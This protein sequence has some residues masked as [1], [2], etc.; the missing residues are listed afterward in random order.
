MCQTCF[1]GNLKKKGHTTPHKR[2]LWQSIAC[3]KPG[4]PHLREEVWRQATIEVKSGWISEPNRHGKFGWDSEK[5][6]RRFPLHQQGKIRCADDFRK[7][8]TNVMT[9]PDSKITLP[10]VSTLSEIAYRFMQAGRYHFGRV[11]IRMFTGNYLSR[12]STAYITSYASQ[13]WQAIG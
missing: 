2:S 1:P 11:T 5:P 4:P 10:S 9:S 7:S 13:T 8:G 3:S 12:L 6:C